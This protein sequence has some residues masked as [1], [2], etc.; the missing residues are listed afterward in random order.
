MMCSQFLEELKCEYQTEN[1]GGVRN[2][3]TLLGSQHFGGV[4]G[5]AGTRDGTRK[6]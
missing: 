1:S 5:R 3:S 4:E 2:W 6:N